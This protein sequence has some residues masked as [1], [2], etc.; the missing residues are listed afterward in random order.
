MTPEIYESIKYSSGSNVERASVQEYGR[1]IDWWGLGCIL[2]ELLAGIAPFVQ[3][4]QLEDYIKAE[5]DETSF[6][7]LKQR[8]IAERTELMVL[9]GVSRAI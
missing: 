6:Y 8:V 2:Y 3:I 9:F 5:E 4:R 7:W 1:A